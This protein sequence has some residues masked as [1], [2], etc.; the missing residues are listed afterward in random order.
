VQ[1]KQKKTKKEKKEK[2]KKSNMTAI[3]YCSL[4]KN[5]TEDRL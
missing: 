3:Y 2:K 4:H 1:A 5:K